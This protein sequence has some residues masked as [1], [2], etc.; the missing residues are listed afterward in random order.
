MLFKRKN[1]NLVSEFFPH[2]IKIEKTRRQKI[3]LIFFWAVIILVIVPILWALIF[4]LKMG[5]ELWQVEKQ[6]VQLEPEIKA[7]NWSVISSGLNAAEQ[8]VSM[9][10]DDL[11]R[12][13]PILYL[14]PVNKIVRNLEALLFTTDDLLSGYGKISAIFGEIK[15][16]LGQNSS[17][18]SDGASR[19]QM[20][21]IIKDKKSEFLKAGEDIKAAEAD[22][23]KIN[24]LDFPEPLRS[25]VLQLHGILKQGADGADL[26]LPIIGNLP[27]ILG[28]DGQKTY[29]LIFQNNMELRPTG[30]FIGSYGLLKINNGEIVDLTID[31]VYNLDKLAE[32]KLKIPAPDPM[33]K[34][35]NQQY[36]FMRDANWSPDW[37]TSAKQI[38]SFWDQERQVAG[39]PTEHID[40]VI[41]L[42][43][44]F[45]ASLLNVIG[46][47]MAGNISFTGD[48]F[49]QVL[50]KFVEFDYVKRGISKTDR[51]AI[52]GDLA[53]TIINNIRQ[54]DSHQALNVINTFKKSID[55]KEILV[56]LNDASI[57]QDFNNQN[58][59]G[60]V[61][62]T[63]GDYL[64]VVDSNLGA[65]KTDQ[66]MKR[67][68]GYQVSQN[69]SG[70]LIGRADITY[71]QNGK[72]VPGIIRE[73]RD[74]V[75]VYLP[76]GVQVNRAYF[77]QDGKQKELSLTK[78]VTFGKEFGKT[79]VATFLYV[80]PMTQLNLV[81]EYKLP[82]NIKDSYLNGDY[83][84]LV[85]KQPG[86]DGHNLQISLN[87]GH[88]ISGWLAANQP[89]K[90]SGNEA[91]WQDVL[92]EDKEY[93]VKF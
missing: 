51:K 50:E 83:K 26:A 46:P 20:L 88:K 29:L 91:V 61:R 5:Y 73:Y 2:P 41:G 60:M 58:W 6:I 84:L 24:F 37:P 35:M 82:Q 76:D 39:L 49:A 4:G 79:Y 59:S 66:V 12:M 56:Y 57:Q 11:L 69:K 52:M 7:G 38:N 77:E 25:K 10:S 47:V 43:P 15:S 62:P 48:N 17:P 28:V 93:E 23:A 45:T 89:T 19:E 32:G 34:Y 53:N 75:R 8:N 65:L 87:L 70:D 13:G 9:A 31:D 80:N 33:I 54:L 63:T 36:W 18:L 22:I 16:S 30:G 92:S 74:Y 71:I 67:A 14:P 72:P 64:W 44:E 27:E 78:D 55:Q 40:G 21:L 68:I 85:Q 90:L 81:L 1:K 86:T 3:S 42:S